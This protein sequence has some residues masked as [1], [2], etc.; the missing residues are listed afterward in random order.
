M[1]VLI[2]GG[3]SGI[4]RAIA[5]HRA[6]L[7]EDVVINY[8]SDDAAAE[9]TA[10]LVTEAGGR[11]LL[12]KADVSTAEGVAAVGAAV[13]ETGSA[14]RLFVHCA[15]TAVPGGGL[16][17]D[18]VAYQRAV[19]INATS[20]VPLTQAVFPA[21]SRGS[22]IVFVSSRGAYSYV[23]SYIA[24]GPAKALGEALIRYLA[25]ELAPHGITAN[26]VSAGALDTPAFRGM[27][28][29]DSDAFLASEAASNPSGRGLEL[30]DLL[31]AVDFLAGPGADMV[32][33]QVLMVDGGIS[34]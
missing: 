10:A 31:G 21:M 28:G 4:G 18:P 25:V 17:I 6:P 15:A 3:S 7:D 12:V 24:L 9:A 33:G 13:A 2:T 34:L 1:S 30:T 11:P 16:D 8:S 26:T 32:Q 20:L 19:A 27:F 23:P 5:V 22:R 14:L 29:A